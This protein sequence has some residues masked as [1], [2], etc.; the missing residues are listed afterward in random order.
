MKSRTGTVECLC[1]IAY[2][3]YAYRVVLCL[4]NP[5]M[6]PVSAGFC[7]PKKPGS[8]PPPKKDTEV[9]VAQKKAS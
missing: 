7:S 3:M 8:S 9:C 6:L 5:F 4:F 1:I 2:I